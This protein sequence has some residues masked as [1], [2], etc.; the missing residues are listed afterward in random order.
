MIYVASHKV[1][2]QDTGGSYHCR[3]MPG[4]SLSPFSD[5]PG[6]CAH[7]RSHSIVP[8]SHAA[9]L[10]SV[11][12]PGPNICFFCIS[13]REIGT[14]QGNVIGTDVNF[15]TAHGFFLTLI[16]YRAD[17]DSWFTV[18]RNRSMAPLNASEYPLKAAWYELGCAT[19]V[20]LDTV[21]PRL[22]RVR[23]D[24]IKIAHQRRALAQGRGE[25][26]SS[27]STSLADPK[28]RVGTGRSDMMPFGF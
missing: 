26:R 20:G 10:C 25:M 2:R 11:Y 22:P 28:M 23:D 14:R 19:G 21:V 8:L 15:V 12:R 16:P 1:S 3:M 27:V 5:Q 13:L 4:W 7:R 17:K 9:C 6:A 24:C 18:L